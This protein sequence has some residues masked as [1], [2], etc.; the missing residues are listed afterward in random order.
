VP[1]TTVGGSNSIYIESECGSE[2]YHPV[3]LEPGQIL[4]FDAFHLKHGSLR[5]DTATT[6]VSFDFRFQP[7]IPDRVREL[8]IAAGPLR[9]EGNGRG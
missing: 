6:R 7:N 3:S 2:D 5:N 4:L 8:G 1:L 9:E